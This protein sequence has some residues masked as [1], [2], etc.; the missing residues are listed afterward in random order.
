MNTSR[1]HRR[2]ALQALAWGPLTAGVWPEVFARTAADLPVWMPAPTPSHQALVQHFVARGLPVRLLSD[3]NDLGAPLRTAPLVLMGPQALRQGLSQGLRGP[4]LAVVTSAQAHEALGSGRDW[5]AGWTVL[6]TDTGM[7]AQMQLMAALFERRISVGVILSDT[8]EHL[9]R[10]LRAAASEQGFSLLIERANQTD[11][12]VRALPRL[13][14]AQAIVAVSDAQL[15]TPD[16]LRIL[17][18]T[19]YRRGQPV[20]GFS[21]ATV[22]AGTLATAHSDVSDLGADVQDWFERHRD[23]ATLLLPGEQ[24]H[25]RYWRVRVNE[26]VAR[27][28]GITAVDRVQRLGVRPAGGKG[29]P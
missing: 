7:A 6:C 11:G 17:L 5:P 2:T 27:S 13:A 28:L 14:I 26:S 24:R 10:P 12:M 25:A 4:V 8:S 22:Q 16:S 21:P 23:S 18:E 19:T 20:I 9:E 3:G 15:Y 29:A 1:M